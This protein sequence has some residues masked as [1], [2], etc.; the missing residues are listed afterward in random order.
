MLQSILL[1]SLPL[2]F[3]ALAGYD[4]GYEQVRAISVGI[5]L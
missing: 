3:A 4:G 5:I 1:H 2:R